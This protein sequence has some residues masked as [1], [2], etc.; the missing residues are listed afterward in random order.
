MAL[1]QQTSFTYD[2]VANWFTNNVVLIFRI[3]LTS[4]GKLPSRCLVG[5][6]GVPSHISSN[7]VAQNSP[8]NS[9]MFIS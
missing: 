3:L 1:F 9:P 8:S 6:S 4:S 2:E 7:L 5:V